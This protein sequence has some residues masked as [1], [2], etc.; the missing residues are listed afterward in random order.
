MRGLMVETQDLVRRGTRMSSRSHLLGLNIVLASSTRDEA[1]FNGLEICEVGSPKR[2]VCCDGFLYQ[3]KINQVPCIRPTKCGLTT[4]NRVF[5][6]K[7]PCHYQLAFS[8]LMS[9]STSSRHHS[10]VSKTLLS[11]HGFC[12]DS[13]E[14][15]KST[16][17]F[18]PN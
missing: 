2:V 5:T 3:K 8:L 15:K 1:S 10:Q 9:M 16:F 17:K 13:K 12:L 7:K 6:N 18:G 11:P 14:Y 4:T